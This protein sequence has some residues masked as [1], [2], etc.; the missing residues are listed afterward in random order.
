MTSEPGTAVVRRYLEALAGDQFAEPIV[1]VLLDRCV[2]R[3]QL[4]CGN[5]L[6]RQY[7]RLTLPPMN[8]HPDSMLSAVVERL[9]KAVAVARPR[10][11]RQSFALLNQHMRWELNDL[12]RRPDEMSRRPSWSPT[13]ARCRYRPA[14]A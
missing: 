13:E 12:A 9:L 14:P 5:L 7:R 6:Y 3:L 8:L 4:L 2:R 11:V 10:T 1:L